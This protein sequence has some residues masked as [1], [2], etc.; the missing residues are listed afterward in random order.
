MHRAITIPSLV[1]ASLLALPALAAPPEGKGHKKDKDGH[2]HSY[3]EPSGVHVDA[4]IGGLGSISISTGDAR[5]IAERH[6]YVGYSALPPGI[7]KNLARGK[8]LPPGIAKK[9]VPAPMLRE[10]PV[11]SGHEWRVAGDDLILVSLG[12]GLIVEVMGDIFR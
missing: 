7:R 6:G 5:R 3:S 4:G 10:L 8:P 11:Y 2:T 12:N 1:L 9:M